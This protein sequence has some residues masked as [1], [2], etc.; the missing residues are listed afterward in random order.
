MTGM[1]HAWTGW[2]RRAGF[3]R[4]YGFHSLRHTAVTNEDRASKD[5]FLAERF[6]R[7]ASPLTTVYTHPSDEDMQRSLRR[8]GC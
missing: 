6:A 8:L 7:Q 5:L 2:Q 4:T 1:Q 3:D